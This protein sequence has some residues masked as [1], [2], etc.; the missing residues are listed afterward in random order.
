MLLLLLLFPVLFLVTTA[1]ASFFFFSSFLFYFYFS[2]AT[3]AT[4]CAN[5]GAVAVNL[6]L[7]LFGLLYSMIQH[8][9]D[10]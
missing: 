6:L 7:F 4:Q 8:A 3:S 10:V 1:A 2:I 5:I 9:R